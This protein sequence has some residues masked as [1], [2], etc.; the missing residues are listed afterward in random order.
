MA[1]VCER[2]SLSFQNIDGGQRK[3]RASLFVEFVTFL[4]RNSISDTGILLIFGFLDNRLLLTIIETF[5]FNLYLFCDTFCA[6]SHSHRN[7]SFLRC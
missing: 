7:R 5:N 3:H 6:D 2:Y 4:V 1:L